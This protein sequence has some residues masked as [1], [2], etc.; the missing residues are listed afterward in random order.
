LTAYFQVV[1]RSADDESEGLHRRGKRP[2]D[3]SSR[4]QRNRCP[5]RSDVCDG[6]FAVHHNIGNI[7]ATVDGAALASGSAGPYQ[8]AVKV[9]GSLTDGNWP[10]QSSIGGMLSPAGTIQ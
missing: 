1:H 2:S 7:P 9:P 3:N 10:T 8:V 4:T 6:H 5:K